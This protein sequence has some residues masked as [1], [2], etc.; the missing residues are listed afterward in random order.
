LKVVPDSL[1]AILAS[2]FES[3]PGSSEKE[4][5]LSMQEVGG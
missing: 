3:C 2:N 5:L 1:S 4:H